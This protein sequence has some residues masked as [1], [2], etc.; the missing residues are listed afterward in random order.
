MIQKRR[1][2]P[3]SRIK[4]LSDLANKTVEEVKQDLFIHQ[5]IYTNAL[6]QN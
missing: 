4:E 6:Y 5:K 3:D 1:E 2:Y